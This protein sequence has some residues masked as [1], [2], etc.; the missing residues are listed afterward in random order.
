M[1][2]PA[3]LVV[4]AVLGHLLWRGLRDLY[5]RPMFLRSNYRGR[6][7]PTSVGLVLSL[8]VFLT[9]AAVVTLG[10]IGPDAPGPAQRALTLTALAVGGFALVGL[11]DDVAVDQGSSGY[12]GHLRALRSGRLSAGSLKLLVGPAVAVVA[13]QPVVG[14]SVVQLLLDGA[15]VALAANLANLFDRAP[16]RVTKVTL[17]CTVALGVGAWVGSELPYELLGLLVVLG[18]ALGVLAPELRE[19]LML[20]DAG[21]NVLGAAA[22]LAVVLTLSATS[23]LVVLVALGALNLLSER[24]SFSRVIDRVAPLRWLD[25]L[26]RPGTSTGAS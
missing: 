3:G 26:G 22:G 24:V 16:G 4:G 25:R 14:G 13:V 10:S 9:T 19:E 1:I 18:A 12:R 8:A 6:E 20:G 11:V 2:L 5:A 21:A 15:L 23:R 7:L 17:A